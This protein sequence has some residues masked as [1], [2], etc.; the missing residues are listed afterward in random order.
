MSLPLDP[1]SQRRADE[2]FF[3]AISP[4]AALI[5]APKVAEIMLN[6]DGVVWID[7]DGVGMKDSGVRIAT[8]PAEVLIRTVASAA[9]GERELNP[10]HPV[11]SCQAR[12][13]EFRFEGL[14]PPAVRAPTFTIRKYLKRNVVLGDYLDGVLTKSQVDALKTAAWNHGQTILLGGQ[15][16]SGKTTL[17]NALIREAAGDT[18]RMLIIEDTPELLVPEG[19]SLRLEVT[20]GSGFGYPEAVA[21]ALRQCPAGIILGEVR[22]PDDAMQAVEAWNTGH[23]GMGTIHAPSCTGML[24]RL[25]SLCRQSESGRHVLQRTISDAV[26]MV[27]HLKR[28]NGRRVADVKRVV[29]WN[30]ALGNFELAEVV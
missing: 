23:Q 24:W 28:V 22:K 27:V 6:P 21:S 7:V 25:Y 20:P 3:S 10:R 12:N 2:A 17:L 18:R 26:H 19:P 4:I 5:D 1:V 9:G 13:G 15:T 30:E 14:I 16:F 8:G 11:V 29:G